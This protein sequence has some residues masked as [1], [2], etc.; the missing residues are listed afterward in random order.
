MGSS[1]GARVDLQTGCF[2][3]SPYHFLRTLAGVAVGFGACLDNL[4]FSGIH[5][6]GGHAFFLQAGAEAEGPDRGLAA[7]TFGGVSV[8]TVAQG[9]ALEEK[10][11]AAQEFVDAPFLRL[12]NS[13]VVFRESEALDI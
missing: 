4:A 11:R 3:P 13:A 6:D 1:P 8:D 9:A 12:I 5:L 2:R 7:A 10:L